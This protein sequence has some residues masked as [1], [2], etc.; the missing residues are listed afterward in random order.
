MAGVLG[1][2]VGA[3]LALG[4]SGWNWGAD[5]LLTNLVAIAVPATMVVAVDARSAR[6]DLETGLDPADEIGERFS[7]ILGHSLIALIALHRGDLRAAREAAAA[8]ENASLEQA[9]RAFSNLSMRSISQTGSG[10]RTT[11][12]QMLARALVLE[13]SGDASEAFATLAGF[14]DQ[15]VRAGLTLQCS[16]FAPDLVRLSLA[17]LRGPRG[18]R[19][20]GRRS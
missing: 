6:P 5:A 2:G 18:I 11:P 15:C 10:P 19:D 17:A 7:V 3:A 1:W 14:W 8:S 4:L 9:A 16:V 20:V 12:E 13:A